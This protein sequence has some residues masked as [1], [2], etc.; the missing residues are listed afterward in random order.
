[1]RTEELS[2]AV[3]DYLKAIYALD[4]AGV[5]V[6]TSA[7]ADRMEVSAPSATAMMKRLAHLGLAER[8][9]YRGVVL[10]DAGRR[11]ALE[12]LRH[13]RLLERYLTDTLG[14]PL[15]KVH[16]EADRLE[17]AISEA[18]EE[19]IDEALGFPTHDPHG[20]PIPDKDLNIPSTETRALLDLAPGDRSTVTRVPD[21]DAE[22]LLYLAELGLLPGEPFELTAI[23]PFGG[24][25]SVR[26]GTGEHAIG[27]ELAA[28]V[29]VH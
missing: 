15:D 2:Q 10:T 19:R 22:L 17:H 16:A 4:A 5:R 13:H 7:L 27:R 24:P 25:I 1:M 8:A 23:A 14:V 12:V 9:P 28:V 21:N 6:T 3:Q 26:T 18:L 11:R 20:D 29:G